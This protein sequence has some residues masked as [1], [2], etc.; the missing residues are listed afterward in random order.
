MFG[1][2][3]NT[4]P[5]ESRIMAYFD[6]WRA[7][8]K[9]TSFPFCVDPDHRQHHLIIGVGSVSDTGSVTSTYYYYIPGKTRSSS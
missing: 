7:F 3:K 2:H 8:L 4:P 5:S 1:C 9:M 6:S